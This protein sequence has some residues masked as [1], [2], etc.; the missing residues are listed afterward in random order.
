MY[1]MNKINKQKHF[2]DHVNLVHPVQCLSALGL[3]WGLST[4][5]AIKSAEVVLATDDLARH[6]G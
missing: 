1:R 2:P 4:G 5:S 3:R 6:T